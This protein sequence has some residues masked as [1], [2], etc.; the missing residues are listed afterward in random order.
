MR[1]Q[2]S[3]L[4]APP[5][6]PASAYLRGLVLPIVNMGDSSEPLTVSVEPGRYLVKAILPS[7]EILTQEID[8]A[9][10]ERVS[11]DLVSEDSP[12]EWLSK[13]Q[14]AGAVPSRRMAEL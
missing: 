6:K 7:G 8:A 4:S 1:S 5:N 3:F 2:T 12:H 11:V 10:P 9:G 14:L 13:Q